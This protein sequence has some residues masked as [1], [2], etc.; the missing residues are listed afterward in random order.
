MLRSTLLRRCPQ[1]RSAP[2]YVLATS[3]QLLAL[4]TAVLLTP[5]M[6]QSAEIRRSAA[7]RII[8]SPWSSCANLKCC[9]G[10]GRGLQI[11]NSRTIR[12][13]TRGDCRGLS[14]PV[15]AVHQ[16]RRKS[17]T[18]LA[19]SSFA[20]NGYAPSPLPSL[21]RQSNMVRSRC[22]N[23]HPALCVRAAVC[24]QMQAAKAHRG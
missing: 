13:T 20:M 7:M 10:R 6:L 9:S 15:A 2:S 8:L 11:V 21:N 5:R 23:S 1:C 24:R 19:H 18:Y 3:I 4:S 16:N 17:T 14:G 12:C 22:Q